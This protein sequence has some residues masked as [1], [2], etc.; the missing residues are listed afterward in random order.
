HRVWENT[1]YREGDFTS[2]AGDDAAPVF[3][4]PFQLHDVGPQTWRQTSQEFRIASPMGET[5][6][7]QLGLFIWNMRSE[8]NFTRWASCQN[9][10]GQNDAILAANPGLT[11]N[12]ND[13]V[14]ATAYMATE[15]E[16]YALFGEG[17]YNF[18]DDQR[19]LYGARLTYDDVGY[20]HHRIN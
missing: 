10:S 19:I 16:N 4:V 15:F 3:G 18:A 20:K 13:I 12:A 6:V 14:D 9:N 7:Y 11:C 1:E 17:K 8:R 5:N 2:I